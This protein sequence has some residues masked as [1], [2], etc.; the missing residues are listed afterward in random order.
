MALFPRNLAAECEGIVKLFELETVGDVLTA[1]KDTEVVDHVKA[2]SDEEQASW[3]KL[4]EWAHAKH[5]Q[6]LD[7]ISRAA[8]SGQA[9][10]MRLS[11]SSQS[12]QPPTTATA[13]LAPLPASK[14]RRVTDLQATERAQRRRAAERILAIVREAGTKSSLSAEFNEACRPGWEECYLEVLTGG[15]T[16]AGFEHK[17]LQKAS[18]AWTRWC[19]WL[20]EKDPQCTPFHP[21]PVQLSSFFKAVSKKGPTAAQGV[22]SSLEWLRR[23]AGLQMLPLRSSVV[24]HF[25]LA[26]A[27]HLPAQQTPLSINGFG[28]LISKLEGN[29]E[30]WVKCAAALVLKVVLSG[31]RLAHV[32]RA[33]RM[34]DESTPRTEVWKIHRGK[35]ADRAGFKTATPTYIAPGLKLET[36]ISDMKPEQEVFMHVLLPDIK[37][38]DKG[39]EG[40]CSFTEGRMSRNKFLDIAS[41]LLQETEDERVTGYTFRRFLPTVADALQFPIEKRQCLGNWVDTVADKSGHRTKE[42]MAVR[43]SQVRLENTAQLKRVCVAAVAHVHAWTQ[44]QQSPATWEQ[45]AGC[46]KSI[47]TLEE[48]TRRSKWGKCS[49]SEAMSTTPPAAQVEASSDE[50]SSSSSNGS[51][52]SSP[53]S[54]DPD[55]ED[56]HL[57][58]LSHPWL[59]DV[60]WI[61]PTRSKKVH[62][63]KTLDV[64]L[65]EPSVMPLCRARPYSTGYKSGMGI[66]TANELNFVWCNRCLQ[67]LAQK[68]AQEGSA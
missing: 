47:P 15:D 40:D 17:T 41:W 33:T 21:Q 42:P 68:H 30:P 62:V 39:L 32:A 66:G 53:S 5:G 63:Q 22:F 9:P 4:V 37:I 61:A 65:D 10:R 28:V 56:G 6:A 26:H 14:R 49:T 50:E 11:T 36:F 67:L 48:N 60:R 52:S 27:G 35:C 54:S 38:G 44:T 13:T 55:T 57:P 31:L 51:T 59:K 24:D 64:P 34:P 20:K 29:F 16:Q 8:A 58:T 7:R 45:V 19:N 43:Y 1:S 2:S 25:K 18:A 3:N 46:I 23:H 12:P